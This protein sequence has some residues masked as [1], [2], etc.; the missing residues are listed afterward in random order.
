MADTSTSTQTTPAKRPGLFHDVRPKELPRTVR[1]DARALYHFYI[2][3]ESRGRAAKMNA[4]K[5]TFVVSFWLLRSML[6]RL[7]PT[8]RVLLALAIGLSLFGA[9]SFD[10][11]GN[12]VS[13][14][15]GPWPFIIVLFVL[16]LELKD[17]IL[18]RD[19]IAVA[20]QVQLALL[21]S[22]DPQLPGFSL[23]SHTVPANDVGGDLIDFLGTAAPD[24]LG[25]ALGDV[26][27]KGLGAALLMAKLQASLHAIAP[28][29]LNLAELGSRLNDILNREGLDN[30][31]ATL[32]YVQLPFSETGPATL[33]LLN[34]GHNPPLLVRASGVEL[35][36]DAGRPLGMFPA[37]PYTEGRVEMQPSDLLIIYSDGLVEARNAMDEEFGMERLQAMA[38]G[39]RGRP[40]AEAGR[41]LLSEVER[42][43][44]DNRPQDDLSLIL[45]RRA[46]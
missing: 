43:L 19:E 28:G 29:C 46:G 5:R 44:G 10:V 1:R 9:F 4:L 21:P 23:F 22:R 24:S 18:A 13:I 2:D 8:R 3:E 17:K 26:A 33:R 25:V 32:V 42:F 35:L 30:R 34:A 27:G 38:P 45:I 6:M 31:F 20:R 16:A 39:L 37:S 12:K 14:D 36:L 7:T 15:F 41:A 11:R 40:P